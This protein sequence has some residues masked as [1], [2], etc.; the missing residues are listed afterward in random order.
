MTRIAAPAER[1]AP[2]FLALL[3]SLVVLLLVFGLPLLELVYVS[4]HPTGGPAQIG[5]GLT[6][7]NYTVVFED[8]L[9]ADVMARTVGLGLA[10]VLCCLVVGYPV[11]YLL[12]RA[13][14]SWRGTAFF[15]VT[16]SLL[17]S[18]VVRNLGWFPILGESGVVNWILTSTGV[19]QT[20]LR[21]VGN[22]V[23][24]MIGLVHA[25]LPIMILTLTT[26]I[27]RIEPDL[28]EAAQSL[29]GGPVAVFWRVLLPLSLPGVISGS[30][31][32]FTLSISA[33]TTPAILGG[34]RVLI[35]AI[36]IA[37]Q[38]Q[39][40]LDYPAGASAAIMLLVTAAGLTWAATRIRA[41][42]GEAG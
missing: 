25:E 15:L 11:S 22:I 10:V 33:F 39:I 42:G 34:N 21:L 36:Y 17:V 1:R 40:V 27:R 4:F 6:L 24:V 8:R 32:I 30:L 3:P 13:T 5:P 9:F 18:S 12:A 19:I 35:M 23:G 41:R 37:Q 7:E 29:G 26:V 14:G 31:L 20:P 2:W 16:V 28:E 38:F